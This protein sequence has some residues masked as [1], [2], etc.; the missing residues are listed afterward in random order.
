MELDEKGFIDLSDAALSGFLSIF[1]DVGSKKLIN[2]YKCY[3]AL[4]RIK[5]CCFLLDEKG[6]S[7][8]HY[9][10]KIKAI[11]RLFNLAYSYALGM[12][13]PLTL[14]FYGLSGS[15]KS[16][17]AKYFAD[18][19]GCAYFNTD[20]CRKEM[21]NIQA[22]E[23]NYVPFGNSIYSEDNTLKVYDYLGEKAYNKGLV[24]RF[25]VIDGTFLK[26]LYLHT[27]LDERGLNIFKI[28]CE[29]PMD[30]LKNRL[31]N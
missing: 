1:N 14:L 18:T 13:E 19:F 8:E 12:Y 23:R 25:T 11:E 29:A 26:K 21:L 17:N 10:T 7:W 4:V 24:G 31:K 30:I 6:S 5:V 28:K 15:G 3:R 22:Y 9:E 2:F 27:F 16:K 20:M